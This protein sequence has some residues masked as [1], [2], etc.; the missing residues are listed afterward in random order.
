MSL[1]KPLSGA[2]AGL[3]LCAL[4]SS[5]SVIN[6]NTSMKEDNIPIN[7]NTKYKVASAEIISLD[8]KS[9]TTPLA[10]DNLT[11]LNTALNNQP[12]REFEKFWQKNI[13]RIRN[14]P[15]AQ[16]EIS[17]NVSRWKINTRSIAPTMFTI[18]DGTPVNVRAVIFVCPDSFNPWWMSAYLLTATILAPLEKSCMGGACVAI[19][20]PAGKTI[21]S[22]TII[23]TRSYWA[24]TLF[25][26]AL[27]AYGDNAIKAAGTTPE[28]NEK[29]L[30]VRI[31]SK[32]VVDML[33][34]KSAS[35][36]SP[37]WINK[38]RGRRIGR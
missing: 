10:E 14:N 8:L 30:Q 7:L 26:W 12:G 37:E 33:N 3:G 16:T 23:F 32:M 38:I 4:L 2:V 15:T 36:D 34:S 24:S 25:P 28:L 17:N 18:K 19:L 1:L 20:D 11:L 35:K 27:F 22:K 13:N 21:D 29:D 31:M 6:Y 9:E 5:C